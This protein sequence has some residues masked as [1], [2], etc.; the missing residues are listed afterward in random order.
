MNKE[1]IK[2]V[3][4]LEENEDIKDVNPSEEISLD[5]LDDV[6]GGALMRRRSTTKK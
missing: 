1:D 6:S 2:D 4:N 3:Q 5:T